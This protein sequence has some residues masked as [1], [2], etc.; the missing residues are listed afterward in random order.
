MTPIKLLRSLAQEALQ[1]ANMEKGEYNSQEECI[2]GFLKNV[3][4]GKQKGSLDIPIGNSNEGHH[5]NKDQI[6]LCMD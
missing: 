6:V 3:D 5:D 2:S 1:Q 4:V